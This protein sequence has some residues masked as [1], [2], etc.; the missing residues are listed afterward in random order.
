VKV[1]FAAETENVIEN[2]KRKP[3]RHGH[4]DL[5]CA[6]DVSQSDSGF[7]VDTN[8]VTII[9]AA[10][11]AEELPLMTKYDVAQRIFDRLVPVLDRRRPR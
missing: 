9:D 7:G 2:A 5:I 1:G 11:E 4:L 6:N 3:L 8:R 10:G